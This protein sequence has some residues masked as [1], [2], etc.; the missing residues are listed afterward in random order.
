MLE[1]EEMPARDRLFHFINTLQPWAQEELRWREVME[2]TAPLVNKNLD[3]RSSAPRTRFWKP[4][5]PREERRFQKRNRWRRGR[6]WCVQANPLPAEEHRHAPTNQPTRVFPVRRAARDAR[7]SESGEDV[8]PIPWAEPSMGSQGLDEGA[9]TSG[10]IMKNY[11]DWVNMI[12]QFTMFWGERGVNL[13]L[14]K[15]VH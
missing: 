1:V 10:A 7:L 4:S 15:M 9:A 11:F 5:Q 14:T 6:R 12:Y 3:Y 13:I 2:A 8:H